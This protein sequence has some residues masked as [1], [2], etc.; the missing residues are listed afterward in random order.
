MVIRQQER[1]DRGVGQSLKPHLEVFS[2]IWQILHF[3]VNA[4]FL[5]L[6]YTELFWCPRALLTA[7]N[8]LLWKGVLLSAELLVTGWRPAIKTQVARICLYL[9]TSFSSSQII[10]PSTPASSICLNLARDG[11]PPPFY[12][13]FPWYLAFRQSL[14]LPFP[15][16]ASV[17]S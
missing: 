6:Y 13:V 11:H 1:E 2:T 7:E 14:E 10:L 5:F 9:V 15:K 4:D 12:Q 3:S 17:L 8:P 16:P